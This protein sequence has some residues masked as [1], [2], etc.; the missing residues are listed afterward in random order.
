MANYNNSNI[1]EFDEID[2]EGTISEEG[3]E[4]VLLPEGD[5]EYTVSKIIRTR[6]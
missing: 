6:H 5:Y 3:Q 1:N 2:F 4:F